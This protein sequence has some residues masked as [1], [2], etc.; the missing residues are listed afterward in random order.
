MLRLV[1]RLP[2]ALSVIGAELTTWLGCLMFRRHRLGL[3]SIVLTLVGVV[4]TF[5]VAPKQSTVPAQSTVT[6]QTIPSLRQWTSRPGSSY[7]FRVNSRIVIDRRNAN[8]LSAAAA[9][10]AD[11]L[12]T[13]TGATIRVL[14]GSAGSLRD[15]DFF[16]ELGPLDPAMGYEGYRLDVGAA[17]IISA[18][19][20]AGCFEGTRTVLQLLR[21]GRAIPGGTASDW[22]MYRERALMVDIGLKFFSVA[23]LK[24]QIRELSYLK[25]NQFHLH[26]SDDL[27]YRLES[28]T[29]P[30]IVA[31]EHYTK[32]DIRE[33]VAF[34]SRYHVTIIPEIDMPAHMTAMLAPHPELQLVNTAGEPRGTA[35]DL[36][37][38]AAYQFMQDIIEEDLPLFPGPYWHLGGDEYLSESEIGNYTQLSAY[39]RAHFGPNAGAWDT[40]FAF[41]NWADAIVRSSNKVL[42]VWNDQLL[43][44]STVKVNSDVII[45][46][47]SGPRD[48]EPQT[49]VAEGHDIMNSNEDF[50]YYVLGG[51]H[52]DPEHI[53]KDFRVNSFAGGQSIAPGDPRLLGAQ[54]AIWTDHPDAESESEIAVGIMASLRSVSE[55]NWGSRRSMSDYTR[56]Q[57]VT[58]KVG[59]APGYEATS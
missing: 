4:C 42:R 52:P 21:Q 40:Y 14:T 11:D 17:I 6:P 35:I 33:L 36:S 38:E 39:A 9:T 3:V 29:H 47:W 50:L 10:F 37:E 41:I 55:V 23:W 24:N 49:I 2:H 32:D 46:H 34:A 43:S 59:R 8:K 48:P 54:L 53:Y 16:L 12:N 7:T 26:L 57:Q 28:A 18:R 13:L 58:A 25:F 51:A 1:P 56:F 5:A 44:G 30:E 19:S 22:P 45:D 27:G 15:G 31:S 20:E